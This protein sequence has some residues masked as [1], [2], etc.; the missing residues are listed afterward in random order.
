MAIAQTAVVTS[1]NLFTQSFANL[2]NLV[3]DKTKVPDVVDMRGSLSTRQ[4]VYS[5]EPDVTNMKF[6]GYPF[7][8]IFP[9]DID[10]SEFNI[11]GT[12]ARMEQEFKIEIRCSDRIRGKEGSGKADRKGLKY[13]DEMSD[14]FIKAL[15]EDT[16][17]G[18]YK[19]RNLIPIS[20]GI[21]PIDDENGD[22]IWVRR[23][24]IDLFDRIT[25]S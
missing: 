3:N 24:R 5:R 25:V 21:E 2:F 20:D 7:L 12:K 22:L 15:L 17:L 1:S 13:L 10:F 8:I 4:M 23:F 16:T 11:S 18:Q 14:N 9:A 6:E 19:M